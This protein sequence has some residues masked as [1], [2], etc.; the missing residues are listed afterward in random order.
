MP[1]LELLFPYKLHLFISEAGA[2]EGEGDEEEYDAEKP[3]PGDEKTLAVDES[4]EQFAPVASFKVDDFTGAAHLGYPILVPPGRNGLAP[5]LSLSYSS[6]GGNSWV[7]VGWDIPTGFIQRRDPRKGVPKYDETNDVYEINLGGAPQELVPIGS[8]EYRLKIEG[9]YLWIKYYSSGNYWVVKDKSGTTMKFGSTSGTTSGSRIG[10]DLDPT[11]KN[12]TF[13][14]YL[15]R[16]EDSK[17]N[18]MEIIYWKDTGS[19]IDPKFLQIY[20][21]KIQYNGQVAG[22]LAHDHEILFTLEG[23]DGP[24]PIYSTNRSDQIYNYRGGFKIRTRKRLQ[25]IEVKTNGN[26]VR[27][28]KLDYFPL[29]SVSPRSLLQMITLYGN[30]GTSTLPATKFYYQTHSTGFEK[31]PSAWPNPS[32]LYF[33]DPC[34]NLIGGNLIRNADPG[35]TG[36]YTDVIDMDSDA[37]QDRIVYDKDPPYVPPY[38]FWKFYVNDLSHFDGGV[39]WKN[40]SSWDSVHGNYIR[41]TNSYGT[42]AD[43]MDMDGDTLPDRVVY[44]QVTSEYKTWK[45]F[46]NELIGFQG[47]IYDDGKDWFNPSGGEAIVGN[48]IR[49]RNAWGTYTDV[50]DM[51]A[52]GRPDRVVYNDDC[53][54]PYET[55]CPWTVYFNNGNGFD[56]QT[57]PNWPNPSAW[58]AI[59]GNHIR[60]SNAYGTYT[61]LIDMNGDGLPDRVVYD[62]ESPYTPPDSYWTVY[63]NNGSGFDPGVHWYNPSAWSVIN[64]NY[65][66]NTS[67]FGTYTD[68]IDINGDG[69][70]DRVV[71]DRF[72][73]YIPPDSFW[74]VY[75]NNGSG[76]NEGVDWENPGAWALTGGNYIRENYFDGVYVYGTRADVIDMDGDG[77]ADRVLYD[78]DNPYNTWSVYYNNGPVP[79]LLWKME[80]GIGGS[81]EITYMP[82]TAYV[83]SEGK[84]LNHLPFVIQTVS[85]YTVKSNKDGTGASYTTE[86][87]YADGFYE[88]SE[89]EFRGFG[90]VT[91]C[92]PNCQAYESFTVTEFHQQ[93]Y[94]LKG[95]VISQTLT[96]KEGHTRLVENTWNNEDLGNG[97][98]FPRLDEAI[99][100][101]TDLDQG[102]PYIYKHKSSY[103]Y[104]T[105]FN[106]Q[107]EHK[108][109]L[110]GTQWGED[111]QTYFA[112]TNFTEPRIF[113]KPTDIKVMDGSGN[114]VSRKW[115]DY[116][117]ATG[118]LEK[119]EVCKS[120]SP[121]S[122]CLNRNETQNSVIN[123]HYDTTY[124]VL[125]QVTDAMGYSTTLTYESTKTF[126]H[127]TTNYLG[128]TTTTEYDLGTGNLT[129]LIPPHLQGTSF[130]EYTYDPFGRKDHEYRPDG[131]WT[132]YEYINFGSATSQ[133]IK[134]REHII[135][136]P[137]VLDHYTNNYFDGMGRT[138]W[139]S[140]S[141]PNDQWIITETQFDTMGRVLWKS[142]PYFDTD[143]P[144]HP[145]T[146]FYYDGLSRGVD[147]ITPDGYHITTTYQGLKKIVTN[148][149]Q[150]STAYTND[151][152]QR[153]KKV[154]EDY[155]VS[156]G[157]SYSVT[158]Y[159]YDTLG[160]L[161]Q[162]IAAKGATEQNTT[163][164]TYDSLSKKIAMADPDM[165]NWS[166]EYDKSGNLAKQTDP[167]NPTQ[168]IIF[169]Y[170][171]LNRLTQKIYPDRTVT[172][173]YDDPAVPYSKG[174]LTKVSDPSGGE[175]KED[176]VLEYDLM[177]RV[178][179]SQKTIPG[180]SPVIFEKGYDSA[181]RAVAITYPGSR[182]YSYEYDVAGNLLYLKDNASGNHLVDYS[183]FTALGQAKYGT[184]PKPNNVSVKS[185][186]TYD[187]PTARV[188]T[189][190]TQKLVGGTPTETFQD[191]NYQ[192]FDGKGNLTTLID[193]LNSI[194]HSY[195]YDNLDRL[196]T[197][198]GVGTNPYSQ[199]YT[200]DHIGNITY[201]SDVGTYNYT[202]SNRPHAV[203]YTTGSININLQY[204]A[205]GNMTQRAVAGGTTLDLTYNYD[206]KPTLIKKDGADHISFTYDGNSQRVKKYN[207]ATLQT[208]LY[209]GG[210]YE[211]RNGVE[212]FHLFAGSRRIASVRSDGKTQFYHPNHLGSASV[213]TDQNG[214]KKEKIEYFPFGT[215]RE[216]LDY[217]PTFP[218][219]NYTFTDQEDDDEFGFYNYGARLYDPLLG[220]FISPDSLVPD[221]GDPQ[222]LNRYTYCLNNPLIYTDPSGEF[223]AVLWPFVATMALLGAQGAYSAYRNGEDTLGII[224]AGAISAGINAVGIAA[225][226]MAG[227]IVTEL[228]TPAALAE[229]GASSSAANIIGAMSGGFTGGAVS[230]GGNAAVNGG[231]V[232]QAALY[233]GLIGAAVAGLIQGAIE[234]NNLGNSNSGVLVKDPKTGELISAER[235]AYKEVARILGIT[236]QTKQFAE[237]QFQ[238]R[239]YA[240]IFKLKDSGGAMA[241]QIEDVCGAGIGCHSA[242]DLKATA[243]KFDSETLHIRSFPN[244]I[245]FHWDRFNLNVSFGNFAKHVWF[246][247]AV[248]TYYAVKHLG[249][250]GFLEGL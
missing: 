153:L 231:N 67:S 208:A 59:Y 200:Y 129:I 161:T 54:A 108:W 99:S 115:M 120:D 50:I 116:N 195:T 128:H 139:V 174:K 207:H 214:D 140:S 177:Q 180:S 209:F 23:Q 111:I 103:V 105:Y 131:G 217:D 136:G 235:A 34:T 17:T 184:L 244:R 37:L 179:R 203:N 205:N 66:R 130:I 225:G 236:D 84:K 117:S 70:P 206:N 35:G 8:D 227:G 32:C 157:Q 53:S 137:S 160:N 233:G 15:D 49:N 222:A 47:D 162:V 9:A 33:S 230:G 173:T 13:R 10:K 93:D 224:K 171:G 52:D 110:E 246:D 18:Y 30:D 232:W 181:G 239:N 29:T 248:N 31:E 132:F 11:E 149:R 94:Y 211:V 16:V 219:V 150:K 158:E 89:L 56:E 138:Y 197:A 51:N 118:D 6:S 141:A 85:S 27:K 36:T 175:I 61:D 71:Y 91:T 82:S 250:A 102:V 21:Q 73:P 20:L 12:R 189:L 215:Y 134:K 182:T 42:F 183:E 63:F 78:K 2:A 92:Q 226:I 96:S 144:P 83:D 72:S 104:D 151:V 249:W 74:R 170:D 88:S 106:V 192:Q 220:R 143:P 113:S 156:T 44:D 64:G 25:Y 7:G 76:F 122:G 216:A 167:K 127:D 4:L 210:S 62:R 81:T 218:D 213:I 109:H 145:G 154:E 166:Y 234:L 202:Y 14:W 146:T 68:V 55:N 155:N 22:G 5:K 95:K 38:S 80:N 159:S 43:V 165:G 242:F 199:N 204:D 46:L 178:K 48:Y 152:Y 77:L 163:S 69:L 19:H 28:Y 142:N 3:P 100:T 193:N 133:H 186:Y 240:Y 148:Q 223:F 45:V 79:D 135:G 41:N 87:I 164:M 172:F 168:G 176:K 112:Y 196:L 228:L 243:W 187:P 24:D 169:N 191:L 188:K 221:P 39:N 194:T 185:T 97:I 98:K 65:I 1:H 107:W 201:K 60:N 40:A 241:Q 247:M 238:I 123:Y 190:I 75:L 121:A 198:Q 57:D 101:I 90:Y 119:E 126:V 212:V 237:D 86:Y 124:K 245:E 114:I 229:I 147:T 58:S 125:D 26:L